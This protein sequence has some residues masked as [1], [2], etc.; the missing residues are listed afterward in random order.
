MKQDYVE[1][2]KWYTLAHDAPLFEVVAK[3][4]RDRLILK[5]TQEQINKGQK[6]VEKFVATQG[7]SEPIPEPSFVDHLKLSG[8]TGSQKHRLAIIN[9]HTFETGEDGTVKIDGRMVNIHCLEIRDGSVLIK[10]EGLERP[11]E[12]KLK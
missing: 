8:I 5:M 11:M 2:Y 9:N 4:Y 3:V 6:Q 1:A 7:A 10:A 12:L